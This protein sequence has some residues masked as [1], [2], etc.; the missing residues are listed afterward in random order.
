MTLGCGYP[1]G[2]FQLLD[3]AGAAVVLAGLRA[4]HAAYGDPAFAPPPLLAEHAAA[5]HSAFQRRP[6]YRAVSEPAQGGP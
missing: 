2:P 4:M 6:Q 3:E 1:R 5:G